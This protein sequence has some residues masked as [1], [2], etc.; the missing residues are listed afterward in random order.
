MFEYESSPI[1]WCE[2]NYIVSAY[3]CEIINTITGCIFVIFSLLEIYNLWNIKS[4]LELSTW[5]IFLLHL[6]TG[7]GTVLFHGTLSL[8][9]Q[10]LDEM[11]I[12]VLI[13]ALYYDYKKDVYLLLFGGISLLLPTYN[14]IFLF[15]S[16]FIILFQ[17]R[18]MNIL[19]LNRRLKYLSNRFIIQLEVGIFFWLIDLFLCDSLLIS[20]H[21]LWHIFSGLFLHNFISLLIYK[22][23][24]SK[25]K[26]LDYKYIILLK[27][28]V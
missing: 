20:L 21:W 12:L 16:S 9:G 10:Y 7:I 24:E 19:G 26:L 1:D 27:S 8:F 14:R 13:L 17:V 5:F 4:N 11:S 25:L 18:Y 3:I 2:N 22:K 28:G 15:I 23:Y 6:T